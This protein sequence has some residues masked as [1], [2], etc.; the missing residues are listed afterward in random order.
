ML[1]TNSRTEEMVVVRVCVC[2]AQAKEHAQKPRLQRASC[3][4]TEALTCTPM[5][6]NIASTNVRTGMD[7]RN[8]RGT[9]LHVPRTCKPRGVSPTDLHPT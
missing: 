8:G 4:P 7:V 3:P 2:R 6:R 9:R 5:A 1:V